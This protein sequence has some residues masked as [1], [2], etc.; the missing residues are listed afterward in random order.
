MVCSSLKTYTEG[1]FIRFDTGLCWKLTVFLNRHRTLLWTQL[2]S[3]QMQT[4]KKGLQTTPLTVLWSRT[5]DALALQSGS[6]A[7]RLHVASH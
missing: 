7:T 2:M 1:A 6:L 5:P 3:I 4:R